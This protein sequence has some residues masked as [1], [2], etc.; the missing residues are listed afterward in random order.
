MQFELRFESIS[1]DIFL[2]FAGFL[3]QIYYGFAEKID[4]VFLG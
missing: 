2:C 4:E 1:H 3:G